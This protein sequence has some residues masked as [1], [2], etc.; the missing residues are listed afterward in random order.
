[1]TEQK[2]IGV[3]MSVN[4]GTIVILLD[5]TVTSLRR[6]LNGKEY[7]IGQIGSYVLIPVGS[8]IVVA[9]VSDLERKDVSKTS[10]LPVRATRAKQSR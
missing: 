2:F 4:S 6:E 7:T 10:G 3:V 1:M 9:M 8:Q 5:D